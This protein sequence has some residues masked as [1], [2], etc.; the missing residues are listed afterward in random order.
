M[1]DLVEIFL[2]FYRESK[3]TFVFG[4]KSFHGLSINIRKISIEEYDS[5]REYLFQQFNY[6]TTTSKPIIYSHN[7]KVYNATHL[8]YGPNHSDK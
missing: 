6:N 4:D 1:N 5:Y 2:I 3:T 8:R 7:H